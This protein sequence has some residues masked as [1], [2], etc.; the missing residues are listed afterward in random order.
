MSDHTLS[1]SMRPRSLD[2]VIG[3]GDIV[4][5]IKKQ[6]S[7]GRIPV[8]WMFSGP[9]GVGKTT[10]ALILARLVQ[11]PDFPADQEP[12]LDVVNASYFNKIDDVR[13]MIRAAEYRPMVGRYKV[14]ILDEAQRLTEAAQNTLLIPMDPAKEGEE[15]STIWMLCTTD[16][17]KILPALRGRCLGFRLREMRDK[18]VHALVER[19]YRALHIEPTAAA[20]QMFISI[21]LE[22]NVRSPRDILMAL[23]RWAGGMEAHEAVQTE[24]D[25]PEYAEIAKAVVNGNWGGARALL[26]TLRSADVRGLRAVIVAFLKGA[27][28]NAE[29]PKQ[30]EPYASSLLR[31]EISPFEDGV[32]FGTTVGH[33]Y[34]TCKTIREAN[35]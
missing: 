7:S 3:S 2:E 18:E 26:K 21:L 15:V 25:R 5:A 19:G 28:L 4:A 29:S 10:L 35:K 20:A 13:E 30:A 23:E 17:D 12:D 11:G 27:L 16:P 34:E 9:T 32:A 33:L 24:D 22:R 6:L 8:G 14:V 31:F 1:I